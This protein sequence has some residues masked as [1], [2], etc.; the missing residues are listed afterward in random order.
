M[1]SDITLTFGKH[2]GKKLSEIPRSYVSWLAEKALQSDVKQAAQ[3]FLEE[4]PGSPSRNRVAGFAPRTYQEASKLGWMAGKG[5]GNAKATLLAA[6]DEHGFLVVEDEEDDSLEYCL[7]SVSDSGSVIDA[8]A[9]FSSMSYEQVEEVLKRYPQVEA[10]RYLVEVAEREE[11][12]AE[13]ARHRLILTSQD[14]KH[15][16]VL[17]IWDAKN[18]EV[19]INGHEHGT[20]I[21]RELTEKERRDPHWQAAIAALEPD[22]DDPFGY[23]GSRA[24][25]LTAARKAFIE[26][27]I[28]E[29]SGR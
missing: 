28:Q 23:P 29:V 7:L 18:I 4:H 17:L 24:I 14:G 26:Q 1:S 25:G 21:L 3:S 6:R 12:E 22:V 10:S 19:T 5:Y 9:G 20:Y 27:K 15:T 2:N 13:E 11:D 8:S 16:I